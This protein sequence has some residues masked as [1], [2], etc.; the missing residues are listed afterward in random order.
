[1]LTKVAFHLSG[2][3][4]LTSQFLSEAHEF[5]ELVLARMALLADHSCK[6]LSL[7]SAK[8]RKFGELWRE[9]VRARL[10]PFHL[11]WPEPAPFGLQERTNGKRQDF[12]QLRFL[13]MRT[14]L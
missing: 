1:M 7:R 14:T 11:N 3:A 9:N 13:K 2:L 4:G 12:V 10:G 8:A 6:V 5:S